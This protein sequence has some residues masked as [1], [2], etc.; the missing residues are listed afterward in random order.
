MGF[1]GG[2]EI[3]YNEQSKEKENEKYLAQGLSL[4]LGPERSK[5]VMQKI[6]REKTKAIQIF[7]D[8]GL[9]KGLSKSIMREL[10][11]SGLSID[12][13]REMSRGLK[14]ILRRFTEGNVSLTLE[15]FKGVWNSL[16]LY[17]KQFLISLQVLKD[18]ILHIQRL[19]LQQ[20]RDRF[21]IL[22]IPK[23]DN[24]IFQQ[25]LQRYSHLNNIALNLDNGKKILNKND[26][27]PSEYIKNFGNEYETFKEQKTY[28]EQKNKNNKK[29]NQNNAKRFYENLYNIAKE[30]KN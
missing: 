19:V 28:Q 9:E 29:E 12:Q 5:G 17:I 27:N 24:T 18:E 21:N 20:N 8:I 7:R 30:I 26:M 13:L 22:N 23:L 25:P 11:K 16:P 15:P 4:F 10:Q 3:Y 1:A 14:L 6:E 2:L